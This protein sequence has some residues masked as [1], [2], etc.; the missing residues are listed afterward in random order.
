MLYTIVSVHITSINQI[1]ATR[2]I[3]NCASLLDQECIYGLHKN[4]LEKLPFQ[5]FKVTHLLKPS[6]LPRGHSINN[7]LF[8]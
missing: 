7:A 8:V 1:L 5:S 2:V 3:M 4:F 6:V